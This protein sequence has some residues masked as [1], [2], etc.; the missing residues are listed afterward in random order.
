MQ[1]PNVDFEAERDFAQYKDR[2]MPIY[3]ELTGRT[4]YQ[5]LAMKV[6]C[7][8][9]GFEYL[10]FPGE[11]MGF[12]THGEPFAKKFLETLKARDEFY[13]SL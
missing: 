1:Y 6:L 12:L 3:G 8:K 4:A 13:R 9:F 7:E 10:E 5:F 11:H 2:L